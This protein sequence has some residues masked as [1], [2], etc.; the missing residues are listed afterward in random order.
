[1]QARTIGLGAAAGQL[2]FARMATAS[3]AKQLRLV[4]HVTS[5][6]ELLPTA[7]DLLEAALKLPDFG[8]HITKA[9]TTEKFA[10]AW[11]SQVWV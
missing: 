3:E 2:Q 4:D 1:M 10:V 6:A 11:E 7:E 8:R 9:R 5:T